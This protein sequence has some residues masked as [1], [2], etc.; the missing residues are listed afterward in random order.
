MRNTL[1]C[2]Q[3]HVPIYVVVVAVVVVVVVVVV[4][5]H[6]SLVDGGPRGHDAP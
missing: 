6:Q 5:L 4:K 1:N 2:S 3:Y